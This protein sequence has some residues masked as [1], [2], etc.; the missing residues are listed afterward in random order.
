MGVNYKHIVGVTVV[1]TVM[2]NYK[3]IEKVIVFG[4]T[5]GNSE[6]TNAFVHYS[7]MI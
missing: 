6:Q 4:W 3:G 7:T 2:T 5:K 1:W